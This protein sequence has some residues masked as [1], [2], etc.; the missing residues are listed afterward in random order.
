MKDSED[1]S[2]QNA[3]SSSGFEIDD[4]DY[5]IHK[6]Y[7]KYFKNM[8]SI[9]GEGFMKLIGYPIRIKQFHDTEKINE[10]GGELHIDNL[11]ESDEPKMYI[12]EFHTGPIRKKDLRRFGSYQTL[13]FKETG[14]ETIVN[15]ISLD[16]KEDSDE[17]FGFGKF[18]DE[19][20]TD[21]NSLKIEYGVTPHVKSLTGLDLSLYLN[22]MDK[23]IENNKKPD[24][25]DLAILF[26]IPFMADDEEKKRELIFETVRI[27]LKLNIDDKNL[28]IAIGENLIILALTVLSIEEF[29]EYMDVMKMLDED[30]VFK[31][32]MYIKQAKEKLAFKEGEEIGEEKVVKKL[33]EDGF[34]IEDVLKYT[35]LNKSQ[36]TSLANSIIIK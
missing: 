26:T 27:A 18:F 25:Y 9:A 15:V 36:V 1:F 34:K 12:N 11:I 22:I 24:Q 23:I 33:L 8:M 19:D 21:E 20:S 2:L 7:D 5:R 13:G 31:I 32:G 16:A 28:F 17:L 35:N 29:L 30:D 6:P 14:L 10:I 3:D 4:R